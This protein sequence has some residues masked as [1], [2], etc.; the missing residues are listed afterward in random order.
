MPVDESLTSPADFFEAI[1]V[2]GVFDGEFQEFEG[3]V[4]RTL[5]VCVV[6]FLLPVDGARDFT[7]D[8]GELLDEAEYVPL[9][10]CELFVLILFSSGFVV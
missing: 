6:I 1:L 4:E 2:F 9:P 10:C 7:A 8:V 3:A 5:C